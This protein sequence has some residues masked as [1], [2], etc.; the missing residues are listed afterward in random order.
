MNAVSKSWK[1]IYNCY[2]TPVRKFLTHFPELKK[3]TS[4]NIMGFK[5]KKSYCH[6]M[7]NV[8]KI[9]QT[10]HEFLLSLYWNDKCNWSSSADSDYGKH[11]QLPGKYIKTV[12]QL[13]NC[14]FSWKVVSGAFCWPI[15]HHWLDQ[16]TLCLYAKPTTSVFAA[17]S[18]TQYIRN[19]HTQQFSASPIPL[20]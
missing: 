6:S 19:S 3:C 11:Y 5:A 20:T 1:D 16:T 15:Q 18:V 10:E 14:I 13:H 4:R 12:G 8:R 2:L 9:Q 7:S 17:V